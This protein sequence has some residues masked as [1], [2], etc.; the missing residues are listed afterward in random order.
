MNALPQTWNPQT[1]AAHA[2]FVAELGLPVVELLAPRAG[3]GILDLGC[4]DGVLTEKLVALG[5]DVVGIDA[6]SQQIEAARQKGLQVFV[7]DGHDFDL[8]R[9]FDAVFSNAALHWMREPSCVLNCVR[10]ALQPGGRFVGEFGGAGNVATVCAA[11]KTALTHRG[12]DFDALSPWYFPTVDQYRHEL[13]AAGFQV[14]SI[15]L[16]PRPTELPGDLVAWLETFAGAFVNHLSAAER[17][18]VFEEVR[19][20][21]RPTL[22]DANGLW[23]VDYVRLRFSAVKLG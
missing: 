10:R 22:C 9:T 17:Q 5:C 7:A 11:L 13:I 8:G 21:C 3:E 20:A 19:A 16:L 15:E 1:Y 6:S 4:G 12:H 18:Q 23:V 14:M 2:S